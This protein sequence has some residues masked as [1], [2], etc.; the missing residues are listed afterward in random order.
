M[1][2]EGFAG[3]GGLS[4][5]AG[6]AVACAAL[7]MALAGGASRRSLSLLCCRLRGGAF[8]GGLACP[9]ACW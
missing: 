2:P 1:A 6:R 4:S 5:F 3:F 8:V 9:V 7:F